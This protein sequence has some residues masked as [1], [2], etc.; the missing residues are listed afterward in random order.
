MNFQ[1]LDYLDLKISHHRKQ[2]LN[3]I[4][5]I[6]ISCNIEHLQNQYKHI[7]HTSNSQQKFIVDLLILKS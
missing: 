2:K 3:L 7:P 4:K 5:R 6:K 1:I